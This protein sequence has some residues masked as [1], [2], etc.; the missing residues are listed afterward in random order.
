MSTISPS[1]TN[2]IE[3][4]DVIKGFSILWVVLYHIVGADY[5]TSA[6]YRLPLFFFLSGIFF[7]KKPFDQF[8]LRRINTLIVPFVVFMIIPYLILLFKY[9]FLAKILHVENVGPEKTWSIILGF[10]NIFKFSHDIFH[11]SL[12]LNIPLWFL[13]GLFLIQMFFYGLSFFTD[14]RIYIISISLIIYVISVICLDKGIN[15]PLLIPF[16]FKYLIYYAIGSLYGKKLINYIKVKHNKIVLLI[17]SLPILIIL[18]YINFDSFFQLSLIIKALSF[19]VL[20]FLFFQES[21]QFMVFKPL[22]FFGR[23]SLIV[24]VTHYIIIK[25]SYPLFLRTFQI[26]GIEDMKNSSLYILSMLL[27]VCIGEYFLIILLN[28]Y[29][30]QFVA[31]KDVFIS[32]KVIAERM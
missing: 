18:S 23:N 20:A 5:W 15:G 31:K 7:S 6:P 9:E 3:Y 16:T 21:Y 12:V 27:L 2:R 1:K 25:Q 24:L 32:K 13:I 30:P 11:E 8:F 22:Q 29:F 10:F 4:I 26:M 19:I 28:R 14:K 17:T